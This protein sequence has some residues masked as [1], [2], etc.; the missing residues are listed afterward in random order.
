LG[1]AAIEKHFTLDRNLPGPDHRASIE[2]DELAALVRGVRIA[3]HALGSPI[4][5]PAPCELPNLSL[6]R[7]GLVA[8]TDLK[9]GSRLSREMIGIK[10]PRGGIE[11]GDLSKVLGLELRNDIPEDAPI[12]W[13]DLA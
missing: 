4:K 1:A 5:R 9:K 6:I 13:T 7:K 12:N 8:A 11:P 2:P 3:N 10:R